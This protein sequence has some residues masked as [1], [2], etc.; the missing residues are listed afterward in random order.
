ME[1]DDPDAVVR[2]YL[3]A[4]ARGNAAEA[5]SYLASGE[6]A[7]PFMR[8]ARIEALQSTSNGD[9]TYLVTADVRASSGEYRITCTVAALPQGMMITDHFYVKPQ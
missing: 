3:Y 7:E 9:G 5:A 4:L 6:P 8:G 2:A 1:T